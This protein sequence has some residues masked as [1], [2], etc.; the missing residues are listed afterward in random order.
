[1]AFKV[2]LLEWQTD[3]LS[4]LNFLW[5]SFLPKPDNRGLDTTIWNEIAFFNL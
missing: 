2:L 3:I 5:V 4:N 1:M